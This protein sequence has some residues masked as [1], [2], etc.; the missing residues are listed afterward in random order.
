[1]KQNR[2]SVMPAA[3]FAAE[4]G[5]GGKLELGRLP[6]FFMLF[7]SIVIMLT[8]LLAAFTLFRDVII[9]LPTPVYQYERVSDISYQ[10]HNRPYEY[11]NIP[12]QD[13][14]LVYITAYTESILPVF[15][16]EIS[17]QNEAE[18]NGY[19]QLIAIFREF[20]PS[21]PSV[22]I[23]EDTRPLG[24]RIDL[25]YYGRDL[26]IIQSTE[27]KLADYLAGITDL[28]NN[29]VYQLEI[30]LQTDISVK[31]NSTEVLRLTERPGLKIPLSDATFAVDIIN[32]T[33]TD[34]TIWQIRRWQLELNSLP[35]WVYP[36][37]FVLA[38]ML[39]IFFLVATRSRKTPGFNRQLRKMMRQARGRLMIIGDKAWE[40][41][42]CVTASNYKTMIKTAK[43]LKHPV[44]CFIDNEGPMPE[45]YFYVYYG[46]NNYCYTYNGQPD[47]DW[48]QER[49]SDKKNKS[50][51]NSGRM[52]Q[53]ILFQLPET[54][55]DKK[56]IDDTNSNR[57]ISE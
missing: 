46:E 33:D 31:K 17:S 4:K 48:L 38:L 19:Y 43:R 21:N 55:P 44:F 49:N 39:F 36:V 51:K 10:V 18:F 40:P 26:S 13:M 15:K 32:P 30:G 42:W 9:P 56:E 1:M 57:D 35:E 22:I 3:G 41:E 24:E 7:I 11:N 37:V 12:V 28:D 45:A 34:D 8:S 50:A 16:Y 53:E 20:D 23:S 5:N 29:H 52:E 2:K 14:N 47:R 25:N 27:V 6:R 54:P